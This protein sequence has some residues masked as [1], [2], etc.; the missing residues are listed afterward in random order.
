MDKYAQN[1]IFTKSEMSKIR[2]SRV[3][4]VGCGGLGGYVLE[5]L[6][7]LGMAEITIVDADRLEESNLNR[8]ILAN[9]KNLGKYKVEVAQERISRVNS[10]VRIKAIRQFLTQE[11]AAEILGGN[12][13]IIDALDN[14]ETRKILAHACDEAKIVFVHAAIAGWYGQISTIFPGD[15]TL[16]KIYRAKQEFGIESAIGNPSFTPA[17]LAS[18]Q[19]AEAIKILL[20]KANTLRHK[21][22][23]I[24]LLDTDF[25]LLEF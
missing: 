5:M 16:Q 21:L 22:L 10:Q 25:E 3:C 18:L 11:N 15:N 20:G 14:I 17:L 6:A 24:D 19:V 12:D 23:H 9:E 7:R 13:L 2:S 8:Q 4:I 1:R